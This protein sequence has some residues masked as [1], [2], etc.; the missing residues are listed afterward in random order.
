[1]PN[2]RA[3]NTAEFPLFFGYPDRSLPLISTQQRTNFG[4]SLSQQQPEQ[5]NTISR[6]L[7]SHNRKVLK[8]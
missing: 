8:P 5:F 3:E 6:H 4:H 2:F 7:K 1:M